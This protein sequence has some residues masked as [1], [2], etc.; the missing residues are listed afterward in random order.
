MANLNRQK[1]RRLIQLEMKS[2]MDEDALLAP[3]SLGEPH[4]VD[5]HYDEYDDD[6]DD[7]HDCDPCRNKK[8]GIYEGG[9]DCGCH[10]SKNPYEEEREEDFRHDKNYRID[11]AMQTLTNLGGDVDVDFD[12]D[13]HKH[14]SYM[15]RPQLYKIA[16]YASALLDMVDEN[17]EL[18]DWQESKIAQISQMIGSVYHSLDYNEEYDDHDDLD[19][20][21]IIGMIKTGN[22]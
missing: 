22:I 17:E 5:Y 12:H 3:P 2:L 11:S 18:D 13:D 16:K 7:D 10:G 19:V 4:Y 14:S 20:H 1:L 9:S 15:A 8:L 6:Y 21:D